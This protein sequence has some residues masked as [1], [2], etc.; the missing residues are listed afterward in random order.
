MK[1]KVNTPLQEPAIS[2]A[3][4][5]EG[6]FGFSLIQECLVCGLTT[7]VQNVDLVPNIDKCILNLLVGILRGDT[8]AF[9]N[10]LAFL[11]LIN[12]VPIKPPKLFLTSS[13]QFGALR[14]SFI[15]LI[16]IS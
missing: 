13:I 6:S 8:K 12:H 2:M 15:F 3:N 9:N 4:M 10:V 16:D 7:I 5:K 14:Q 1:K 11:S